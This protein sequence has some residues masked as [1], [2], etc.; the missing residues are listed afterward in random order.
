MVRA[1]GCKIITQKNKGSDKLASINFILCKFC[2]DRNFKSIRKTLIKYRTIIKIS[3]SKVFECYICKSLFETKVNKI[4]NEIINSKNIAITERIKK[5]NI[6]THLPYTIYERE[7]YIRSLFEIKGNPNIK[8][9]F[10]NLLRKM[11]TNEGFFIDYI[12]PDIKIDISMKDNLTYQI[13][14]R[15]KEIILVGHYNKFSRGTSQRNI[16]NNRLEKNISITEQNNLDKTAENKS[17]EQS[18]HSYIAIQFGTNDY[19]IS[20][21]GSEDKDSMVLGKGRPFIVRINNPKTINGH[22]PIKFID[23]VK[24]HFQEIKISDIDLYSKYR[25]KVILWVKIIEHNIKIQAEVLGNVASSLIGNVKFNNKN[26]VVEKK[27]YSSSCR[28]IDANSFQIFLLVDNGIP[29]KQLVGCNEY[30]EPCISKIIGT[31]CECIYFDIENIL[32]DK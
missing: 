11:L 4:Y 25:I 31:K 9:H 30:I 17:I 32:I 7:D 28:I 26:K 2:F 13:D 29:F 14:Y 6:G 23:H 18:I 19:R 1:H 21:T 24:I 22:L 5:I 8:Y 12:D 10:N 20:W 16:Q 15:T 27:I 3:K